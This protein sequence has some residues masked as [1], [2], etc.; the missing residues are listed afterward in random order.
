L[1][2][3]LDPI[4]IPLTFLALGGTC[5]DLDPSTAATLFTPATGT[6]DALMAR[7]L[8]LANGSRKLALVLGLANDH[9]GYFTTLAEY[10]RG[11]YEEQSTLYGPTTGQVVVDSA[12]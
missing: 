5:L 12:D 7:A 10:T 9:G 1:L 4:T 6:Q 3:R 11:E 2:A 8:V